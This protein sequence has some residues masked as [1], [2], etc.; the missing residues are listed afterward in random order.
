MLKTRTSSPW[1]VTLIRVVHGSRHLCFRQ[2]LE[3]GLVA[4]APGN[5]HQ[6]SQSV[7]LDSLTADIL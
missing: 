4:A 7:H 6:A 5:H 2:Q 1:H 3:G